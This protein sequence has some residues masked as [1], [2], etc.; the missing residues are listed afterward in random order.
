MLRHLVGAVYKGVVAA[1]PVGAQRHKRDSGQLNKAA[2]IR[3][4]QGKPFDL[5][6][7]VREVAAGNNNAGVIYHTDV[8][9]HNLFQLMDDPLEKPVCH[10]AP[11]KSVYDI[12]SRT[13]TSYHRF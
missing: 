8:A 10:L 13:I 11:P 5:V 12:C 7:D 9:L 1:D 3:H 6:A 2:F 4:G